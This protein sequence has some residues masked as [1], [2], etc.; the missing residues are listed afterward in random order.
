MS[1][2][3]GERSSSAQELCAAV[4]GVIAESLEHNPDSV[5]RALEVVVER[6][7]AEGRY[8]A[9]EIDAAAAQLRSEFGLTRKVN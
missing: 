3:R 7:K 9:D 5:A 2:R 1:T 4:D 6:C 8:S